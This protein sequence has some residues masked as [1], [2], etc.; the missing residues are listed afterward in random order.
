MSDGGRRDSTWRRVWSIIAGLAVVLA[1]LTGAVALWDRFAPAPAPVATPSPSPRPVFTGDLSTAAGAAAF[2]D[3]AIA[4]DARPVELDLACVDLAFDAACTIERGP[5]GWT[6]L[7]VFEAGRC[8]VNDMSVGPEMEEC[9][10]SS[11]FWVDL[12]TDGSSAFIANGPE[13]AG[14]Y[15]VRG[16]FGLRDQGAGGT[17]FPP[18]IHSYRLVA[19]AD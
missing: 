1:V 19:L 2:I 15:V 3:F 4:H 13:G 12:S 8:A 6:L 18:N 7:W 17:V 16:R 9:Q 11:V 10:G 5:E 14:S